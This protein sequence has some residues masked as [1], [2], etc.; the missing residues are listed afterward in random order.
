MEIIKL[1]WKLSNGEWKSEIIE[2]WME[3]I[4]LCIEIIDLCIEIIELCGSIDH[5]VLLNTWYSH[6]IRNSCKP[7]M[8]E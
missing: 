7:N 6:V 1:W 5:V 3:I 2:L 4:D 8:H